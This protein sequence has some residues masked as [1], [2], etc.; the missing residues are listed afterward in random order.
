MS[1]R[2]IDFDL[3]K[4]NPNKYN[5][6][7]TGI[8]KLKVL[9]W[10]RLKKETWHNEALR[11][12]GSWWC[13]LEGCNASGA[14]DDEVEFWIGFNEDNGKVRSHFTTYGGMCW[15]KPDKFYSVDSISNRYDM[16][17]QA[18]TIRWLNKMIDDGIL[19]V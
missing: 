6:T 4:K 18:N 10:E 16:Q 11:N 14:Y 1:R 3:V 8:N 13:H 19:G 7:P 2:Y 17:M 9:D 5:L 15:Y 12:T